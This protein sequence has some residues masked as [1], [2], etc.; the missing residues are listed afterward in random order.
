MSASSPVTGGGGALFSLSEDDGRRHLPVFRSELPHGVEEWQR[1]GE[2]VR[3]GDCCKGDPDGV[4]GEEAG[5]CR[6][7]RW[8]EPAR[9]ACVGRETALYRNGCDVWPTHPSQIADKPNCSYRFAR[10][11]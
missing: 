1:E 2:C 11:R 3:C 4:V 10:V 7:F 6:H 5:Y 8:E 9:G